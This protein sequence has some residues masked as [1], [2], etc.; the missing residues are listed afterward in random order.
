MDEG[1]R[2]RNFLTV[3][4]FLDKTSALRDTNTDWKFSTFWKTQ[5]VLLAWFNCTVQL[6][7]GKYSAAKNGM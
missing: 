3:K 1:V 2:W 4:K 6:P 5:I 7:P